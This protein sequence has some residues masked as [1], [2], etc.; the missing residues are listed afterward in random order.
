MKKI[1][2][3]NMAFSLLYQVVTMLVGLLLPKIY[4]ET[5][6]SAY[7]G[8]NQSISQIIS[9]LSV[10]QFGISAASIQAMFKPIANEDHNMISAIYHS[11]SR[12]YRK[13]GVFFVAFMVPIVILFPIMVRDEVQYLIVVAFLV[14]RGLS[15]AMEYFFQAKYFVLLTAD[16]KSYIIYILNITITLLSTALHLLILFTVK[17][18][19]AYQAVVLI[20]TFV[21]LLVI[22]TYIKKK[23]PYIN[24]AKHSKDKL[25]IKSRKD[26]LLSEI[27]GLI[28]DSTDLLILTSFSSLINASI[29]SIYHF[30]TAGLGNILSSA[31]E[32]VFAGMGKTFFTDK[33]KFKMKMNLFES[34]Y[35]I[36]SFYLYSVAIILFKP[37][38]EIYT[39]K[40]D[41]NYIYAGF[42]VLF[43]FAKLI[44]NLRIPAIICINTAGHF[45]QVKYYA[46]IEAIINL[47][48]SLLLVKP[49][50][51]YGVLIGTILAGLVRT[52][53]IVW[54]SH[55][56]ILETGVSNYLLKIIRWGTIFIVCWILSE[57]V[58]IK[59]NT[60]FEWVQY[61]VVVAFLVFA[62]FF[63]WCFIFDRKIFCWFKDTIVK[64]I[65][66]KNKEHD[67]L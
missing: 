38:I 54:Y 36:L 15:A 13:M 24:I 19:V 9:F 58:A 51:I 8:L 3:I 47:S 42:P 53:L 7:N 44:V 61:A 23:Y 16:N 20:T 17:N 11:T 63:V 31:R 49:L 43:I 2:T 64:R 10:L 48:V 52:P 33:E 12:Q 56:N 40:M 57:L 55:K 41:V 59:V 21:R 1:A 34:L 27:A 65:N 28:V 5:F 29:Y 50:G 14:F 32:A 62:L 30:V 60:I 39:E 67:L 6:G 66:K 26:V 45:K 46:V 18:I 4:T 22:S 25:D 35:F 37:F